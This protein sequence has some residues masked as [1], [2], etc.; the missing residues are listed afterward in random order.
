M[1]RILARSTRVM[2]LCCFLPPGAR[3]AS[4]LQLPAWLTTGSV[5]RV[6]ADCSGTCRWTCGNATILGGQGTGS[7]CLQAGAPGPLTV[8]CQAPGFSAAG[9][10]TVLPPPHAEPFA[11]PRMHIGERTAASL[12]VPFIRTWHWDGVPGAGASAVINLEAGTP[13]SLRVTGTVEDLAG[14]RDTASCTVEVVQGDFASPGGVMAEAGA[15]TAVRLPSGRVLV[16]GEDR[17]AGLFDPATGT[18]RPAGQ[19]RFEHGPAQREVLLADGT[20]LVAGGSRAPAASETYDPA[21]GR[22]TAAGDLVR[23]RCGH[24]LT[25]LQ[26]GQV[27]ALGGMNVDGGLLADPERY[28][29]ATRRWSVLTPVSRIPPAAR[30]QATAT[31]L[32]DG[33]VLIAGGAGPD[34]R[35]LRS[36]ELYDPRDN[37]WAPGPDLKAGRSWHSATLL[38]EDGSVLV[39]GG[40]DGEHSLASAERYVPAAGAWRPA[41]AMAAARNA[42]G[43]A[44]LAGGHVLVLGGEAGN[45]ILGSAESYDPGAG[46]GRGDAWSPWAPLLLPRAE[47]AVTALAD[48]RVLVAGG[49]NEVT[50]LGCPELGA[51]GRAWTPA[52]GGRPRAAHTATLLADGTVLV[53]GGTGADLASAGAQRCDPAGRIWSDTGP[54]ASPR[55][56]HSATLLQD[57]S[58]LAAGGQGADGQPLASAERYDPLSECWTPA[59]ELADARAMHTA[60]LL[61]DGRVLVAGGR[62][63]VAA[64]AGTELFDGS[65]WAAGPD[66]ATARFGHT[67]TALADG[68]VLVAGG[69]EAGSSALASA[70]RYDPAASAWIAC[71]DLNAPRSGHTATLLASGQVLVVGGACDGVAL[72]SAE[73]FDPRTGAWT[74][75]GSLHSA[76]SGHS[77][78]LV[79][80]KV[81]VAGGS[82]PQGLLADAELYD[83]ATGAWSDAGTLDAP[84]SGHTATLLKDGATV[85]VFGGDPL[86][87]NP[88]SWR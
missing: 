20:V 10:S 38:P 65:A 39:A 36:T 42:H 41:A 54:L 62:G 74:V 45:A 80:G 76:R 2:A 31:R 35:G 51:P 7:L 46:P 75:T 82:G 14:S 70:E 12:A 85:L 11:Q 37:N 77:A 55:M 71:G 33:Q 28:D 59:G 6:S 8:A 87:A 56:N 47:P 15:V 73:L 53:A 40:W 43:A 5:F 67:A 24:T 16:V 64:L 83:P 9:R 18:W 84:R 86:Q 22:W 81:L 4:P 13:G 61:A 68:T 25:R 57:G 79:D 60:T 1:V 27:L 26:D 3:A 49:R 21:T 58:V 23:G 44:L 69:L 50:G 17:G 29:P 19:L 32:A 30:W 78:A 88:E 52:S 34:G 48:G 66:L 72:A 63:E